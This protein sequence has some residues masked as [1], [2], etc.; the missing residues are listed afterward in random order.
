MKNSS[1]FLVSFL[2]IL[3]GKFSDLMTADESAVHVKVSDPSCYE[4][5]KSW[6]NNTL[7]EI[8]SPIFEAQD[9]H[10][11]CKASINCTAWTWANDN[12]HEIQDACFLFS[13]I[14]DQVSFPQCVSGPKSCVCSENYA[15]SATQ[16]NTISYYPNTD[17]E[18]VCQEYCMNTLG[19]EFYTWYDQSEVLTNLCVLLSSCEDNFSDCNGCFTGPADCG[20]IPLPNL[21]I[22]VTGGYD[23]LRSAE[24]LFPNGTYW[25]NL[26]DLPAIRYVHS[27]NGLLTCGGGVPNTNELSSCLTFS[28]GY[29]NYTHKLLQPRSCN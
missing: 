4:V 16:E 22:L 13:S 6:G 28:A 25:C 1:C 20:A 26:P 21:A 11:L 29:W 5:N 7:Q 2:V 24:I 19:C 18:E 12:N 3:N 14:G 15:C 27:Q 8:A 9:C 23:N 17:L 10:R